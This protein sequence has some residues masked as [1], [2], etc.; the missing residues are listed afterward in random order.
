MNES[1]TFNSLW[2]SCLGTVSARVLLLTIKAKVAF[3]NSEVNITSP[4]SATA[5]RTVSG[6]M[7]SEIKYSLILFSK[8]TWGG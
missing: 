2:A 5:V 7:P 6:P 8:I 1:M 3:A 4:V